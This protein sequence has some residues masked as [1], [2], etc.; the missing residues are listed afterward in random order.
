MCQVIQIE[1]TE[2]AIKQLHDEH[3]YN[4]HPRVRQ[5]CGVVYLKA[6]RFS[7]Q[8]IGRITRLSQPTIRRY[9]G[10]YRGGGLEKLK[11]LHFYSPTSDL[12]KHRA[13]VKAEFEACPPRT[14]NEAIER[15]E[16]LT[17]VHFRFL[18]DIKNRES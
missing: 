4:P 7:H 1:F 6:L 13:K 2:E 12:D 16:Q 11:E 10:M 14:L 3:L 5:R 18:G 17:G 8:E 15:I 9:L